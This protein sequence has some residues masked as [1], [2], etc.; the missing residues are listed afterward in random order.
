MTRSWT[1]AV[2]ARRRRRHRHRRDA[3]S[4]GMVFGVRAVGSAV[5]GGRRRRR[6]R[7]SAA[8]GRSPQACVAASCGRCAECAEDEEG[9]IGEG[10]GSVEHVGAVGAQELDRDPVATGARGPLL[11]AAEVGAGGCAAAWPIAVGH[12]RLLGVYGHGACR[13]DGRLIDPRQVVD[14]D[15]RAEGVVL[16]GPAA[17]HW[18]H[19]AW[20]CLR[21]ARRG[22]VAPLDADAVVLRMLDPGRFCSTAQPGVTMAALQVDDDRACAVG[23]RGAR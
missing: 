20:S 2:D 8:R 12:G 14:G 9:R 16:F 11:D 17:L 23:G 7:S 10:G 4:C 19:T 18:P 13:R 21:S 1:E 15:P 6:S 22:R 5:R 3:T